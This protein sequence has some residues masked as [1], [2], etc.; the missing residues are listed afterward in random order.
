MRP[1]LERDQLY[2]RVLALRARGL[3]Y[4][5]IIEAVRTEAGVTLRKSHLHDWIQGKHRP[6]GSVHQFSNE[7]SQELAYLIGVAKGDAALDVQ[8]WNYRIRLRVIDRDFTQEFDRCVCRVLGCRPH[9]IMW[10]DSRS[11]WS[12][13][14]CSLLLYKFLRQPLSK[15]ETAIEH[16]QSC[17]SAFLRGFFDSEGS[18]SGRTLNISNTRLVN[19]SYCKRLLKSLGLSVTGPHMGRKGG[20]LVVI[21]GRLYRANRNQ[22]NLRVRTRSLLDFRNLVGFSIKRKRIALNRALAPNSN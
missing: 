9:S 20:R 2:R 14:V 5:R 22:Y 12:I 1:V 6:L 10:I 8:K 4:S 17:V 18:I 16:C 3:S 11:Q 19:L 13:E 15:L 21:K 7:P